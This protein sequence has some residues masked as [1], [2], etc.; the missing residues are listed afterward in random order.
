MTEYEGIPLTICANVP[1]IEGV[2]IM[3]NPNMYKK[4]DD[5]RIFFERIGVEVANRLE[6]EDG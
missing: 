1:N 4:I 6:K 5:K 3:I 2:V